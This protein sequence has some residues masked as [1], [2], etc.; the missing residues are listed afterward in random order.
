M[1]LFSRLY[2]KSCLH[3]KIIL[4]KVLQIVKNI[5]I[6]NIKNFKLIEKIS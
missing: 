1:A 2:G 5:V 4:E 6:Y 3:F